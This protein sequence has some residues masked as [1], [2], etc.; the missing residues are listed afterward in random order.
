MWPPRVLMLGWEYPPRLAGGL[1]KASQGIARAL[2][3]RGCQVLF[4]LPRYGA[5]RREPG[6]RVADVATWLQQPQGALPRLRRI[7]LPARLQP[8]AQRRRSGDEAAPD[9]AG[10]ISGPVYADLDHEVARYT[11]LAVQLAQQLDCDLLHA[12]DWMSFPAAQA[13][14]RARRWPWCVHVHS[15][16][17]D[18]SGSA[19]SDAHIAAIERT[20]CRAADA[21]FAVS[22]YT[23]EIVARDYGTPPQRLH[24]VHNAPDEP[25]AA[26]P[27]PLAQR[28]LQ[29]TFLGRLAVQKGPDHF[30]AAAALLARMQPQVRFLVCG[31]GPMQAQLQAQAQALGIAARVRFTGFLAPRMAQRVLA[32]S[33]LLLMPS[34]SEPFG[35]V[36]LEALDAGTPV[37]LSRQSGV[38]EV[39]DPNLAAD[40]WD[41]QRLAD[42]M[43]ALLRWP[44]LA[45]QVVA[46]GRAR[47]GRLSWDDAAARILQ[48][49]GEVLQGGAPA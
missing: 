15:T 34:V 3:A 5:M 11:A 36:A 46:D 47:L 28:P 1:G 30:L 10:S 31:E 42:R 2:A 33:R 4:V 32:Q 38:R 8:Y 43:L 7:A 9:A 35:L 44:T 25:P 14:A 22:A 40:F 39:L 29:V 20:A 45:Q 18:R 23:A 13:I 49:Y 16:E 19:G 24:V 26:V 41:H 12:H 17:Y 21:V 48:V 27:P 37:L 6:L